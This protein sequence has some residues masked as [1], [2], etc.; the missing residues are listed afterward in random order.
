[1]PNAQQ[2][3]TSTLIQF[4]Q[5]P[6]ARVSL[7]L[8]LSIGAIIFFAI[9]AIRPTLLTMADLVKEIEDKT[10]LDQQLGQ[11]IAALSTVQNEY[12]A[13]E[14]QLGVLDE[15]IPSQPEIEQALKIVEKIASDNQLVISSIQ[16]QELPEDAPPEVSFDQK[17]RISL[18]MNVNLTGDYQSIRQFIEDLRANRRALI[19]DSIVFSV[20]EQRQN[21]KLRA[22]ITVNIQYFGPSTTTTAANTTRDRTTDTTTE[23]E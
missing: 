6:V 13:V 20:S 2:K 10:E 7:E 23:L 15:A 11:K 21:R 22:T 19:V 16:L 12:F 1:M 9:F 4:Y 17:E 18:P 3:A 14:D 8:I 5:K